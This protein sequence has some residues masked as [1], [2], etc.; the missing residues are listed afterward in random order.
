M[1]FTIF[2]SIAN[3]FLWIMALSIS[4]IKSSMLL[5][6]FPQITIL[7]FE[8][9]S[10][11]PSQVTLYTVHVVIL[12]ALIFCG[13]QLGKDFHYFYFKYIL[14]MEC[15]L[16]M[17]CMLIRECM[18]IMENLRMKV[19]RPVKSLWNLQNLHLLKLLSTSQ[20]NTQCTILCVIHLF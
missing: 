10:P 19:S 16:P 13:R 3:L 1:V 17:E 2:H 8:S 15:T 12:L 20:H 11:S 9:E 4:I 6:A 14:P 18:L 7:Q 5:W